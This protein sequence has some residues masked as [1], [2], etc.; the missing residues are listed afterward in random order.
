MSGSKLGW[1]ALLLALIAA[2]YLNVFYQLGDKHLCDWDEARHGVSA[3]EMLESDNYLVNTFNGEPDYWNAKPPLSFLTMAVG[4]K[5]IGY[6]AL[7]LR[8]FSAVCTIG[9]ALLVLLFGWRVMRSFKLGAFAVFMLLTMTNFIAY[10]NARSGDADALFILLYTASI[11][12]ALLPRAGVSKFYAAVFLSTLTF[13]TKSF[14]AVPLV[15]TLLAFY[16]MDKTVRRKALHLLGCLALGL[17]PIGIWVFLRYQ[18]DGWKFFEGMFFYDVLTR[19][20]TSIEGHGK[21]SNLFLYLSQLRYDLRSWVFLYLPT[22]ALFLFTQWRRKG[23][24]RALGI[25]NK[26]LLT[27]L[28]IGVVIP[29]LIF[30]PARS[31]LDWYYYCACPMFVLFLSALFQHLCRQITAY[32]KQWGATLLVAAMSIFLVSEASIL[33]INAKVA[34]KYHDPAQVEMLAALSGEPEGM[35]NFYYN[36]DWSQ[37]HVLFS[38]LHKN[39]ILHDGGE[40]AYQNSQLANKR[41]IRAEKSN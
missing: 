6:N 34:K 19:S 31:K 39:A 25:E 28:L 1:T 2:G 22:F 30:S 3:V 38:K 8:F 23:K 13:L 35:H 26:E 9:T 14:H 16:F 17:L 37:R 33:R 36:H 18:I 29:I 10:H 12:T 32:S 24:E 5:L 15:I 27:R 7:G 40:R 4:F 41:L 11:F 21:T 20:T